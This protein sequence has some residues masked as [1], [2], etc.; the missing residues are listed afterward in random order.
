VDLRSKYKLGASYIKDRTTFVTCYQLH[1]FAGNI[2]TQYIPSD[3]S[4]VS[5][6]KERLS[7][8]KKSE[9]GTQMNYSTLITLYNQVK[10]AG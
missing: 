6:T 3:H 10:E 7:L 4:Y 9:D 2:T 1:D 5:F 8:K